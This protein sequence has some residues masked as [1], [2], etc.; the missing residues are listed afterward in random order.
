MTKFSHL[1]HALEILRVKHGAALGPPI[2]AHK[3]PFALVII[4]G[5]YG[6]LKGEGLVRILQGVVGGSAWLYLHLAFRALGS[7]HDTS[8]EALR[9]SR[10]MNGNSWFRRFLRSCKPLKVSV[11]GLY[12]VDKGMPLTLAGIILESTVNLLIAEQ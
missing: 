5:I 7:I 3:I 1:Y 9:V 6:A 11:G 2:A 12:Y 8:D 4:R 10:R